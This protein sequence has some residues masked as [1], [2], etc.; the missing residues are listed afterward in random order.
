VADGSAP[1][2][3]RRKLL[4]DLWCG[5][6]GTSTGAAR[7]M[8]DLGQPFTLAA[9]NHW[10][11]AI[12][13]H[14]RNHPEHAERTHCAD[15]EVARPIS[16]VPEG[17]LDLLM[18]SPTCTFHS[19][20]RG[21]KPVN[22]QQRM[23]PW[24]VVRW[25]TELRVKRLLVE[26]VPEIM[27]WGPCSL[28]TGRP[29]PSRKGE[30]F[31]AWIDA[32]KAIG[33][34]LDY[35]V[36]CAADFGDPTTRQRFFLIGRTDR[37]PLRWPSPGYSRTGADDLLDV[38]ARWRGAVEII[39]W[40]LPGNSIFTRKKPL[41]PN[42]VRRILAGAKRYRWPQPY[43]DALQALLDGREPVLDLA[44]ASAD[45]EPFCVHYRGTAPDQVERSTRGVGEPLPALTAGGQHVGL[46]MATGAGGVARD[47]SQPLPTITAGGEG[48][49][50]P[51]FV[52][53]LVMGV[54]GHATAKPVDGPLPTITCGG[55]SSENRPGNARPQLI[56]PLIVSRMNAERGR[57]ARPV[58]EPLST[59]VGRGAGYL[60]EPLVA[61]YY[62][63]GSGL[64][65]SSA[66]EPLPTV[67]TKARFG[68]AEPVVLSTSN[69]SSAGVPRSVEDPL[70]TIT[71]A[72]GGDMAMAA[73]FV[74]PV[75]HHGDL[76]THDIEGP[77]PTITG[78]NRG[79][80]GL[81]APFLVPNFGERDG[82]EP[83]TH[84]IDEPL[85]TITATGHQ[86]LAMPVADGYRI[87]ILYRMLNYRELARGMSLDD[88]GSV[89]DFAGNSTEI[90]K[91]IGNAVPCRLAKA[92]VRALM[93]DGP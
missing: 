4:A 3:V 77:L 19:R 28:V 36:L 53:P 65:A 20:A 62:G 64:T 85:P 22:D 25:C 67:T 35:R 16:I 88:E 43:Q 69:S 7:A 91:Q 33:F 72:K 56:E 70:R 76:R 84:G 27:D 92:L 54:H 6:G 46:I 2:R 74:F 75:T 58:G 10:P 26:N 89:Y 30:Y 45:V 63:G 81:A 49:A 31:R 41:K 42:T 5:A 93:E 60:A 87:D 44:A 57:L 9:V 40:T 78:A 12:D 52:T 61:P 39:D 34:R 13:T 66:D 68:L 90:T 80:L 38:R 59:I 32:L 83:R 17:Y 55:A 50:R 37:G 47:A 48:G 11:T 8:R 23:D 82:Q 21:G 51:H 86:Q 15:L 29:I 71:T 14:R 18:A 73:P 1:I 79:E 24:H